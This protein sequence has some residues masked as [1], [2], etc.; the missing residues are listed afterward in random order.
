MRPK[1][2]QTFRG[3][4]FFSSNVWTKLWQRR[5]DLLTR[6][7]RGT[8]LITLTFNCIFQNQPVKSENLN[9]SPQG[10]RLFIQLNQRFVSILLFVQ[11]RN[12]LKEAAVLLRSFHCFHSL[13]SSLTLMLLLTVCS[14][15]PPS[16]CTS[17]RTFATV[18]GDARRRLVNSLEQT[19]APLLPRF[20]LF[21]PPFFSPL[22]PS[23]SANVRYIFLPLLSTSN[24]PLN[25]SPT[26]DL[27]P[28]PP[29]LPLLSFPLSFPS[30]FPPSSPL[31]GPIL[32]RL[33]PPRH[34]WPPR[35][36]L[37][38]PAEPSAKGH[39]LKS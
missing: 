1:K 30:S 29:F 2:W 19:A 22:P 37:S 38:R 14:A 32:A 35:S 24:H 20:L 21:P 26:F 31:W 10:L 25:F 39:S 16:V 34:R 15:R 8:P 28:S 13:N 5:F 6:D 33:L 9:V 36:D 3:A 4:G 27:S 11:S 23:P 18:T 12:P 17:C 7:E